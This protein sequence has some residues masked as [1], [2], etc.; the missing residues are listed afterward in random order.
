MIRKKLNDMACNIRRSPGDAIA[1]E[2]VIAHARFIGNIRTVS[3][4]SSHNMQETILKKNVLCVID[5]EFRTV[6]REMR[7][8]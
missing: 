4:T 7:L 2:K 6:D 1:G 3:G 5:K 8:K